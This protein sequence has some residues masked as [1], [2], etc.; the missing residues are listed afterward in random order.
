[1]AADKES[2][3]KQMKQQKEDKQ[4][5]LEKVTCKTLLF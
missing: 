5:A 3:Q 2:L 1:M 4:K